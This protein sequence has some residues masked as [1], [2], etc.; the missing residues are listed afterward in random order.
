MRDSI[1][2][3]LGILLV[4][5]GVFCGATQNV[6]A[7]VRHY[8]WTTEYNTLPKEEF[9]LENWVSFKVPDGNPTNE[10]TIEY[11]EELEYGITDRW[12]IAHYQRWKT[13]HQIGPD[14]STV[15]EGFKFETKYRFGEKGKYWVDPLLYLELKTDVRKKHNVN[16]LE[17]KIVLSKDIEKFNATYNQIMESEVDNGGRTEHEFAL[18]AS[19][20][21]LPSVRVGAEFTGQFW[22][23]EGHRNEFSLGPALAYEHKYFWVAAG[24]R[25]GLNHAT[26]DAEARIIIGIPF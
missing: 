17:G 24:G 3:I 9:E 16:A 19:Y 4:G 10:N 26:D 12:T 20:E 1:K 23:P 15:Y 13:I 18:A 21:I 6:F 22:N 2:K 7:H 11:Q 8:V 14:D 25:F 5:V